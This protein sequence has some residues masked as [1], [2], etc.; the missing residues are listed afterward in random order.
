MVAE[1]VDYGA[2]IDIY[3]PWVD[4]KEAYE[5]YRITPINAPEK[6]QYDAIILA[7]SHDEFIQMGADNIHKLGKQSHVLYDV[8][9]LLKTDQVDGRL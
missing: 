3:D 8:K 1:L 7:V 4:K 2:I 9:Y 6:G 5:E